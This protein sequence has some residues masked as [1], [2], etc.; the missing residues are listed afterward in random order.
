[1]NVYLGVDSITGKK[2]KTT[3]TGRTKKEVKAKAQ[4][5]QIDFKLNG[6]TIQKAVTVKNFQELADIWLES[7]KL[8]VKPQT[9]E[10]TLSNLRTHIYPVF[11]NRQLDKIT[12]SDIQVFINQLSRYFENFVTIRSI[13]R[14]IFQQGILLQLVTNNPARDIILPRRQ[15]KA[16]NKV[17]FIAPDDLKAFL[18]NLEKKQYKRYGL[19]YEYVL[20]HLLLSTG[21]RVGEACALEWTDIDLDKSTITVNKTYNKGLKAVSTAKTKS[22]NRTISIDNKT[23]LMLKQYRNRQR[24]LFFETG[25]R[26]PSVVFATPTREYFDLAIRQSALDTRCKEAGIPRFTFHAF[27]HTHASLLLNA[28]ISYKELQYRLGHANITMTLDIYS[29]LSRD[30]EK[31]AVVYFEKAISSL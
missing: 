19:Y 20:Y 25:A 18:D 1:S 16:D 29:H 15:K 5:T 4:Q 2:V 8:T 17:K 21:L 30:K 11:G 31:E 13:I 22:A 12:A 6:S 14:R 27:R 23:I 10:A 24:Q 7:Y 9:Y 3:V 28:G 26:A